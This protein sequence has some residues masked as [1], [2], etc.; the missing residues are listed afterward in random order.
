M[1]KN[2]DFKAKDYEM[3]RI[4][5]DLYEMAEN[6]AIDIQNTTRKRVSTA[7]IINERLE[8]GF[9]VKKKSKNE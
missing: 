2:K 4:R 8:L 3:A 6:E 9:K 1:P 5:P 7:S